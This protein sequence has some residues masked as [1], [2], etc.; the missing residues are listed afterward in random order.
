MKKIPYALLLFLLIFF[1]TVPTF[2]MNEK[3]PAKEYNPKIMSME[4]R[5]QWVEENIPP[6]YFQAEKK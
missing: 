2:A 3:V 6:V 1:V 5:A 4:E